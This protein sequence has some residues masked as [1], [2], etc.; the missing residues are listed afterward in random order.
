MTTT[1]VVRKEIVALA[2]MLVRWKDM[3]TDDPE[4][5]ELHDDIYKAIMQLIGENKKLKVCTAF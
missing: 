2:A 5:R 4:V 1:R 3:D